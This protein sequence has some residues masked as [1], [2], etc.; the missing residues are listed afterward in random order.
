MFLFGIEHEVAFFDKKGQFVDFLSTTFED[1]NVLIR[2]LP[3]YVEDLSQLRIEEDGIKR[4]RWYI[5]GLERFNLSGK[6]TAFLPKGI[7]IRT[8]THTTIQETIVELEENFQLLC[9]V[10]VPRGF[11]PV[12]ISFNPYLTRYMPDP[13]LNKFELRQRRL[14]LD[15]RTAEIPILTYGPD[16]NFSLQGLSDEEII[17]VGR[18][19]TFYSPYII[20]FSYSSPFYGGRLWG[21]RSIRTFVRTGARPSTRVFLSRKS[22]LLARYEPLIKI[23]RI[24]AEMGRIEFKACDS[25]AD[26]AIYAGLLALLK[27]L[28]LDKTLAGRATVPDTALHQLSA[29]EGFTN[30]IIA[31]G[32]KEVAQAA[33]QALGTDPDSQLLVP[34]LAMLQSHK[35][36][37]DDLIMLYKETKSI[38]ITLRSTYADRMN[39]K[40]KR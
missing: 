40:I 15:K 9:E 2:E 38:E 27:G 34:L 22:S 3:F 35:T 1:L 11:D 31:T 12:L 21:G 8:T 26:F 29:H 28:T 37:A 23:A 13:P 20:P 36:P 5:E 17:D 4:K 14:S 18:K 19:L 16:L 7:E 25:C 33:K 32:A 39:I 6:A 10:A 30:Q 24:P